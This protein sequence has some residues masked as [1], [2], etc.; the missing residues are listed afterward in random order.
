D[1]NAGV[2]HTLGDPSV[3]GRVIRGVVSDQINS[4]IRANG[5]ALNVVG[6]AV[7]GRAIDLSAGRT[8]AGLHVDPVDIA[9]EFKVIQ[10][11]VARI[12]PE[13]DRGA[14]AA[15]GRVDD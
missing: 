12:L 7:I 4:A 14:T 2:R 10:P 3:S 9:I 1:P 11:I 5:H 8:R 13:P 15:V 6:K